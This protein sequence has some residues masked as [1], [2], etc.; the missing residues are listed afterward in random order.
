MKN[1]LAL[2]EPLKEQFP[3]ISWADLIQLSSATAVEVCGGPLIDM[4]YGRVDA[5]DDSAV[6]PDGRLPSAGAPYQKVSWQVN[7]NIVDRYI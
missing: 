1:A 3:D 2:L 6:P 7:D 4:Q 5:A